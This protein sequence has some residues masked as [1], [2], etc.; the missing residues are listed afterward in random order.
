MVRGSNPGGSEVY[1]VVQTGLEAHPF[2]CTMGVCCECVIISASSVCLRRNVMGW[3][4][5]FV[6]EKA[7]TLGWRWC[8]WVIQR[9]CFNYTRYMASNVMGKKT[10]N[11]EMAMT[12]FKIDPV[13]QRYSC[14]KTYK[15]NLSLTVGNSS[16]VLTD[17]ACGTGLDLHRYISVG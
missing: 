12:Y 4:L 3:P 10:L 13:I 11:M 6:I 8:K 15:N 5:S 9:C 2:S 1:H 16:Q 17:S 14:T 7:E